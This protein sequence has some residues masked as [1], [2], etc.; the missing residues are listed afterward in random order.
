MECVLAGV[1]AR[2]SGYV[3]Q[4][5]NY[6]KQRFA[7]LT[8]RE[9]QS[10]VGDKRLWIAFAVIVALF[11]VTGPFGTF[12]QLRFAER[13]G[14]WLTIHVAT[15]VI[16]LAGIA[17]VTVWAGDGKPI[18]LKQTV[19]GCCLATPFIGLAVSGVKTLFLQKPFNVSE[20][21]WQMAQALPVAIIIGLVAFYFFRSPD[22]A[23]VAEPQVKPAR[24]DRLMLRLPPEKRGPLL[25]MSM[26]DHYVEVVTS[27]GSEL[28][29]LRLADAIAEAGEGAGLQVHR[30]HWVAFDA[31]ALLARNEGKPVVT[32][33]SGVQLPVSRTYLPVLKQAG[34]QP[35]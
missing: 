28:V 6:V 14:F 15:W 1:L 7:Q 13:L 23:P 11:V 10:L 24:D 27:K 30:S 3:K 19:L 32:T 16:A 35:R 25:Y 34:F 12:D 20:V 8:L 22:P 17:L 21:L 4:G 9:M 31:I 26:Q 2:E 29:L 5:G 33:T 18:G